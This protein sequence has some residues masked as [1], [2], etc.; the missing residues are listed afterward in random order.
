MPDPKDG[1]AGSAVEPAE[2][3]APELADEADPGQVAEVRAE[4]IEAETGKYG[5]KK[6]SPY[7]APTADEQEAE[8]KKA[9]KQKKKQKKARS[10]ADEEISEE[11]AEE[12]A[13]S[14]QLMV[15]QETTVKKTVDWIEIE[16]VGMDDSPI[17]G[18][19]Y[20]VILPDGK[21]V[22]RGTLD[23]KGKAKL[24]GIASGNC[25]ISF[26]ELDQE[27]WEEI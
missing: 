24:V 7:K 5:T 23:T 26:P 16:L 25:Q 3:V 17:A 19:P 22:D 1:E 21:T 2:A 10:E 18:M 12:E 6:V 8:A 13:R 27:A 11:A 4:Q 20:E 14:E 9:E 15:V